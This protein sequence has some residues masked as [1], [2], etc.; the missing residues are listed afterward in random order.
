MK[1]KGEEKQNL[2]L[3]ENKFSKK[4]TRNAKNKTKQIYCLRIYCLFT[5]VTYLKK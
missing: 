4:M 3:T 5:N 2:N 1:E